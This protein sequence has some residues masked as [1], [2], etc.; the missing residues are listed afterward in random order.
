MPYKAQFMY[1]LS[2]LK[3]A[4][5]VHPPRPFISLFQFHLDHK[6]LCHMSAASS[7]HVQ[8]QMLLILPVKSAPQQVMVHLTHKRQSNSLTV[9]TSLH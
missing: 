1:N 5:L 6:H 4:D 9:F 8:L 2:Q 3:I 7:V